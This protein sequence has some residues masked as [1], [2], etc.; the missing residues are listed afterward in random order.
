M[1]ESLSNLRK[2]AFTE[3]FELSYPKYSLAFTGTFIDD[4]KGSVIGKQLYLP[5]SEKH[6]AFT[7]KIVAAPFSKSEIDSIII[8]FETEAERKKI[9][10]IDFRNEIFSIE[11]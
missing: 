8:N 4:S 1:Q 10:D 6:P 11:K 2:F 3:V 7:F 5:S 9:S